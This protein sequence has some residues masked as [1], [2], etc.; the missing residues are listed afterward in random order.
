[1]EVP[2]SVIVPITDKHVS[3]LNWVS[4][5]TLRYL[6]IECYSV[7]SEI[8]VENLEVGS[9]SNSSQQ[10]EMIQG[11]FSNLKDPTFCLDTERK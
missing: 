5:V 1:M 4:S 8:S 11:K 9:G 10:S 7:F 2:V 3:S 6:D